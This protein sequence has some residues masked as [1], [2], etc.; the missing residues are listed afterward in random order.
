MLAKLKSCL[1]F[2]IYF[3]YFQFLFTI[4]SGDFMTPF[5]SPVSEVVTLEDVEKSDESKCAPA[6][7]V[8]VSEVNVMDKITEKCV[9]LSLY[10]H[11]IL[12]SRHYRC[13]MV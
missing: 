9:S 12:V 7:Q 6:C 5:M 2:V 10:D 8:D 3:I 11:C 1:I 13:S 4:V